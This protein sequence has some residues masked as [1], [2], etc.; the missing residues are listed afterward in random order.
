M[1]LARGVAFLLNTGKKQE[2]GGIVID[3][4]Y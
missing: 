2:R 3:V 1:M 4:L